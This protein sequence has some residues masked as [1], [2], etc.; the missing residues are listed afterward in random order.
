MSTRD[1]PR[2][3]TTP[4]SVNGLSAP[5]VDA[6]IADAPRLG[7]GVDTVAEGCTPSG[8]EVEAVSVSGEFGAAPVVTSSLRLTSTWAPSCARYWAR[9]NTKES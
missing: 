3:T 7:I 1:Q 8:A 6:L 4:V 2:R 5:L 9:L